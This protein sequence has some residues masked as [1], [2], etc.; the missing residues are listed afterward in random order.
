[1]RREKRGDSYE[2]LFQHDRVGE[3]VIWGSCHCPPT[4]KQ[5]T[6]WLSSQT[7]DFLRRCRTGRKKRLKT[8][9][10]SMT[11]VLL[12][13]RSRKCQSVPCQCTARWNLANTLGLPGAFLFPLSSKSDA[14][15]VPLSAFLFPLSFPL[16]SR[17]AGLSTTLGLPGA[18]LFPLSSKSAYLVPSPGRDALLFPTAQSREVLLCRLC[19]RMEAP[20][21]G[22]ASAWQ[23]HHAKGLSDRR[24]ALLP[25]PRLSRVASLSPLSR[26]RVRSCQPKKTLSC[27]CSSHQRANSACGTRVTRRRGCSSPRPSLPRPPCPHV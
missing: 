11:G 24:I 23:N 10:R 22:T 26:S 27:R 20:P 17:R 7:W 13:T 5:A 3:R 16:A 2:G 18:F 9:P 19:S 6:A 14:F 1:M 21:L 25:R 8:F 4:T 12:P 15:L